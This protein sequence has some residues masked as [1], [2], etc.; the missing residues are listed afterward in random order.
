MNM[1]LVAPVACPACLGWRSARR[2]LPR[3]SM[4]NTPRRFFVQKALDEREVQA[5]TASTSDGLQHN[6]KDGID[7]V[8]A[9]FVEGGAAASISRTESQ[10]APAAGER[11]AFWGRIAVL[12]LGVSTSMPM[13]VLSLLLLYV[14]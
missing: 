8:R 9:G 12:I 4:Q 14:L 2:E 7:K 6:V 5:E 3:R 11:E 10:D 13:K 1:H